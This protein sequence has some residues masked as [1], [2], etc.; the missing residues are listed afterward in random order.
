MNNAAKNTHEHDF[1]Y[2]CFSFR[3]GRY[4][5]VGLPD[6]VETPHLTFPGTARPFS[7]PLHFSGVPRI[8]HVLQ[9]NGITGSFRRD[10]SKSPRDKFQF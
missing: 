3:L 8:G 7:T 5:E 4:Q 6:Y 1:V 10:S 2:T 9:N